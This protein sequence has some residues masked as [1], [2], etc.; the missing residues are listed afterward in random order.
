MKIWKKKKSVTKEIPSHSK[1]AKQEQSYKNTNTRQPNPQNY[2]HGISNRKTQIETI[3]REE[4]NEEI[5]SKF[6]RRISE[7]WPNEGREW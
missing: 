4:K 7:V 3:I 6:E 1:S 2:S 5:E